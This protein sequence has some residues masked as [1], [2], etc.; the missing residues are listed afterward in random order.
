MSLYHNNCYYYYYC[1]N[2][3]LNKAGK[4]NTRKKCFV[5]E[6]DRECRYKID[7]RTLI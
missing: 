5:R 2:I 4:L 3:L 7:T 1:V 6:R